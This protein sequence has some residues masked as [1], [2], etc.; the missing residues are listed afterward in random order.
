MS[1]WRGLWKGEPSLAWTHL[2]GCHLPPSGL[3]SVYGDS[4]LCYMHVYKFRLPAL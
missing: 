4:M 2:S 3:P 1:R